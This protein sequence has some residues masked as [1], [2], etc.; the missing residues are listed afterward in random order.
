M[1]Y[2]SLF[3]CSI[4]TLAG[5]ELEGLSNLEKFEFWDSKISE[6]PEKFFNSNPN[7][8]E[9]DFNGNKIEK[10]SEKLFENL[11]NLE[12]VDFGGNEI[13]RLEGKIF[14][15]SKKLKAIFLYRNKIS[16]V[17]EEFLE[18]LESLEKLKEL[19]FYQN[20]C[21]DSRAISRSE[22]PNL[23]SRLRENCVERTA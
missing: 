18:N 11:Q 8:K 9:I 7:L 3:N 15:N 19:Y 6:I 1:T 13:E 10:I 2:L 17:S 12:D 22:I 16:K 20:K 14:K 21:I 5:D 4:E 23:I